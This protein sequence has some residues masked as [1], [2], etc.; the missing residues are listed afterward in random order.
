MD[1]I[2]AKVDG[3][4]IFLGNPDSIEL[5]P[6]LYINISGEKFELTL[7][8]EHFY[9]DENEFIFR[10]SIPIKHFE[11]AQKIKSEIFENHVLKFGPF[12]VVKLKDSY[13]N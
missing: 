9:L 2:I 8:V 4:E 12:E 7:S 13:K 1:K 6:I 5:A 3:V 11:L 10:N